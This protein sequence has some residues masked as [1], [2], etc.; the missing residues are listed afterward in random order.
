[1]RRGKQTALQNKYVRGGTHE[2]LSSTGTA[3]IAR[4]AFARCCSSH[5]HA[6]LRDRKHCE[7]GSLGSLADDHCRPD[8]LWFWDYALHVYPQRQRLIV[9]RHRDLSHGWM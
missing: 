8:W 4:R 3:G 1:M 2:K 6:K 9:E 7:G 5:D